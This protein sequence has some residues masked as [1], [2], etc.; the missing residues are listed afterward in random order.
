M[1][2]VF[3]NL[4]QDANIAERYRNQFDELQKAWDAITRYDQ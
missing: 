2:N 4:K 1:A 3:F